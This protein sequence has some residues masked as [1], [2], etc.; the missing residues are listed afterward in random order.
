MIVFP[1]HCRLS[2]ACHLRRCV[3][4]DIYLYSVG[5][6]ALRA[7][8]VRLAIGRPL[9]SSGYALAVLCGDPY[10][11]KHQHYQSDRCDFFRRDR[12]D[13]ALEVRL[14]FVA[15]AVLI[16]ATFRHSYPNVTA[17]HIVRS[18]KAVIAA[19][20]FRSPFGSVLQEPVSV[21]VLR[22]RLTVCVLE[23]DRSRMFAA[24]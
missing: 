18:Y 22:Y 2:S 13:E 10:R 21:Y 20:L 17:L 15:V 23:L 11:N 3:G 24:L 14:I 6:P 8:L 4:V 1:C 19:T 12:C 16:A 5:Q 9:A 7:V